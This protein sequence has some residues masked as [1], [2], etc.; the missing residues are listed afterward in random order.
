MEPDFSHHN[1]SLDRD[2]DSDSMPIKT[3]KDIE[4]GAIEQIKVLL[5]KCNNQNIDLSE[6]SSIEFEQTDP[7]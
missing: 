7:E 2:L 1:D 4:S 6:L 5:Q 3:S